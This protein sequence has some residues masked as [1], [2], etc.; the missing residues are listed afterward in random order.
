MKLDFL[1]DWKRTHD[2]GALRPEHAGQSVVLMG[3]VDRMRD[4]G[5]LKI[6][7]AHV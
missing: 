6:G 2:C 7:R 3:W 4:L 1:G 5:S